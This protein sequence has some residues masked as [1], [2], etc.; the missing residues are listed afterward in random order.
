LSDL[1]TMMAFL[2]SDPKGQGYAVWLGRIG[3]EP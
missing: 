3:R 2:S 1:F